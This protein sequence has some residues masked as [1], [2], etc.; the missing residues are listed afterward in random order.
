M[1]SPDLCCPASPGSDSLPASAPPDGSACPSAQRHGSAR[2]TA[3]QHPPATPE[4]APD[5]ARPRKFPHAPPPDGRRATTHPEHP[6]AMAAPRPALRAPRRAR[7][8]PPW[9]E[10]SH[11][12]AKESNL[13]DPAATPFAYQR[14]D[15]RNGSAGASIA[16]ADACPPTCRPI[17][18]GRGSSRPSSASLKSR[19][20]R[21][22]PTRPRPTAWPH[23]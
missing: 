4:S 11:H 19:L 10:W 22:A 2:S 23:S 3:P 7:P 14:I 12:F 8:P 5:P 13:V 20:R 1:T 9:S 21:T 17:S 6:A 16:A 15:V 18:A